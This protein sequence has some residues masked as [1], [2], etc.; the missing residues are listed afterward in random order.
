MNFNKKVIKLNGIEKEVFKITAKEMIMYIE[1][2]KPEQKKTFANLVFSKQ[3]SSY[4]H[5]VAR[6]IFCELFFPEIME[7]EEK[8]PK[9]KISDIIKSWL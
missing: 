8:E 6:K 2:N 5:F 1:E 4:N 9:E 3:N 7:K